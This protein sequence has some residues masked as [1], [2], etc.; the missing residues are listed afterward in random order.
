MKLAHA[1]AV[2]ALTLLAACGGQSSQSTSNQ[3][4]PPPDGTVAIHMFQG[5]LLV[6]GSGGHGTLSFRGQSYPFSIKGGGVGGIGASTIDAVGEVYHLNNV[7]QFPGNYA[8]GRIGFAIGNTSAGDLWLQNEAGVV[9]HLKAQRSGLILS[10]GG[11]VMI[12]SMP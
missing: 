3:P 10:L 12:I 8:Q 5:A 11:D 7:S 1:I 9:M 4:P 2:T 6:S